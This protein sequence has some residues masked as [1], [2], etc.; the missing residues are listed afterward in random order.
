MHP[1]ITVLS[2]P[3]AITVCHQDPLLR[4]GIQAALRDTP[5]LQL[6]T[7]DALS[8]NPLPMGGDDSRGVILCDYETGLEHLQ[9]CASSRRPRII[10]VTPRQREGEVRHALERGVLGYLL[11]GCRIDEII[12]AVLA[13]DSGRRF[14]SSAAAERVADRFSYEALTGREVEVLTY[15]VVGWSNKM[16]ASRL[17][18]TEGTVKCHVKAI[19]GKLGVRSRTEAANVAMRRGLIT[20]PVSY[21]PVNGY[22]ERAM[23]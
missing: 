13:V 5:G 23:Q 19:L 14:L 2:A 18:V 17:G 1:A 22:R 4:L 12:E 6:V 8:T 10:V 20:E 7:V 3:I 11:T 15:V 16:V 21:P 9:G